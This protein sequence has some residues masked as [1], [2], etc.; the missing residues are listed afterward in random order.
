MQNN[1]DTRQSYGF[2]SVQKNLSVIEIEM[3][4][5]GRID[6]ENAAKYLGVSKKSL[7]T[8]RCKGISPK[9]IK[10]G[11]RVFYYKQ[12]LDEF[13]NSEERFT[14]TAQARTRKEMRNV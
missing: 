14:S 5:D 1:S 7:D 13:L 11:K 2:D 10:K 3:Y 9:F 12:D 6:V 8:W 4:S